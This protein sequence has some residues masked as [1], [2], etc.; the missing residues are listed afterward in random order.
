MHV[1]QEIK[2]LLSYAE[3]NQ[4]EEGAASSSFAPDGAE[5]K[6]E[7]LIPRRDL[8]SQ[9]SLPKEFAQEALHILY[10][11]RPE[12]L[13][14]K[15]WM[16][17]VMNTQYFVQEEDQIR[18]LFS[19]GWTVEAFFG[20]HP[21]APIARFDCMGCALTTPGIAIAKSDE[22]LLSMTSYV[23]ADYTFPKKLMNAHE[24]KL[25]ST[26]IQ[27][28]SPSDHFRSPTG[29]MTEH[30]LGF[31]NEKEKGDYHPRTRTLSLVA[32]SLRLDEDETF[33]V[34]NT[35]WEQRLLDHEFSGVYRAVSL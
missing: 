14:K 6:G 31:L 24:T 29:V 20:C 26:L 12:L 27:K 10:G 7:S 33:K 34:M 9:G 4:S 19:K 8:I 18:D 28:E 1:M 2:T 21:K 35:L 11:L 16:H 25:I 30:M 5:H 13:D 23:K 15:S 32:Q 3:E 17:L 22:R